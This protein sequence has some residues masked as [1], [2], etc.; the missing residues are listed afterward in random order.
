MYTLMGCLTLLS[1]L[2]LLQI[3]SVAPAVADSTRKLQPAGTLWF[4]YFLTTGLVLYTHVYGLF[5]VL[6]QNLFM[7]LRYLPSWPDK[8]T[9]PMRGWIKLQILLGVL[10]APWVLVLAA[11]IN[12]VQASFW[13]HKPYFNA[14][15]ET[16]V[17]Y[18]GSM[19]ALQLAILAAVTGCITLLLPAASA[20]WLQRLSGAEDK[21]IDN[22]ANRGVLSSQSTGLL[23]ALWLLIPILLPYLISQF[24]QSIYLP[25]YTIASSFAWFMLV[26]IG[27]DK[28]PARWL[29][30]GFLAL[31]LV[32]MAGALPFYYS[33]SKRTDWPGTVAFLEER[34]DPA[35]LVFFHSPETLAPYRYY[36]SRDDLELRAVVNADHRSNA[37][38][39]N[40][41]KPDIRHIAQD[42]GQVWLISGYDYQTP[43][44]EREI[45]EQLAES[46]KFFEGQESGA[47]RV[48]QFNRP[49]P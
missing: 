40:D 36:R 43:I 2:L 25:R 41:N 15:R 8:P 19:P 22:N 9:L 10:F 46:H 48:F 3:S 14:L 24:G 1:M 33:S 32:I 18:M 16:F 47:I 29:R 7:A 28:L 11:Q 39:A 12:R 35:A 45:I 30:Y 13:L 6:A 31:L 21:T 4:C 23:L 34:A 27:I 44:T 5:V 49:L 20:R 38:T 37:G 17:A 26:A 42:Y